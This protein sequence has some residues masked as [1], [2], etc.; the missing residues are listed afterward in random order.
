MEED[1]YSYDVYSFYFELSE[2]WYFLQEEIKSKYIYEE[3][4]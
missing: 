3:L 1:F 2:A 4:N